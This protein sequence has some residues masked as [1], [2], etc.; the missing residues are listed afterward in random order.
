MPQ[1][2]WQLLVLF[3]PLQE[4]NE[5]VRTDKR[6]HLL[7]PW[8]VTGLKASCFP[9]WTGKWT[10][11]QYQCLSHS[12]LIRPQQ[13]NLFGKA[14]NSLS[15]FTSST[16]P[17]KWQNFPNAT[18]ISLQVFPQFSAA[19]FFSTDE[20]AKSYGS[21][22]SHSPCS[23]ETDLAVEVH[24]AFKKETLSVKPL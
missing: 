7:F 19:I 22:F 16:S 5:L 21:C 13:L 10:T 3:L 8:R 20:K 9:G 12:R 18:F 23:W 15:D 1:K 24:K 6:N 2:F 11:L 14:F 17:L 4:M